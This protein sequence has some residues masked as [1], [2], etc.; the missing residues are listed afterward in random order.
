VADAGPGRE[1]L[2]GLVGEGGADHPVAGGGEGVVDHGQRARLAGPG[3]ADDG[4]HGVPGAGQVTDHR[5]LL[6]PPG[7]PGSGLLDGR[8]PPSDRGLQGPGWNDGPSDADTG[9]GGV[10]QAGLDRQ[11]L[12]GGAARLPRPLLHRVQQDRLRRVGQELVGMAQHLGCGV[13]S[14]CRTGEPGVA[15]DDVA[16]TEAG[17]RE[18]EAAWTGELPPIPDARIEV[19]RL[20]LQDPGSSG[21]GLRTP[22]GPHSA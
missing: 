8:G 5:E 2:D 19:K 7:E 17:V 13:F 6:G 9:D 4:V 11:Q 22:R 14:G 10:D 16:A 1:L 3:D 20:W 21:E 15:L 18:G 12:R